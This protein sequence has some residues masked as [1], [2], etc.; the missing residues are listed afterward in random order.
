[1][2]G[3]LG[4]A[5]ASRARATCDEWERQDVK[6]KIGIDDKVFEVDVEVLEEDR[7]PS[8]PP[9]GA[10]SGA[11]SAPGAPPPRAAPTG[12]TPEGACTSPIAG[13]VIEVCCEVGAAVEADQPVVVLEAM[14][15]E[16]SISAPRA[17]TVKAIHVAV[18]DSVAVGQNLVE[19]EEA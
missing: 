17:G 7:G 13:T 6:L 2:R 14:K 1:M 5:S 12:P 18:G 4:G 8:L 3:A 11:P 16:S 19:L 9:R 15:M 10:R